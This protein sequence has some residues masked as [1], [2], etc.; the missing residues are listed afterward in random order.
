MMHSAAFLTKRLDLIGQFFRCMQ[1]TSTGFPLPVL[2]RKARRQRV[3]GQVHPPLFYHVAEEVSRFLRLQSYSSRLLQV[4][5]RGLPKARVCRLG[6][7]VLQAWLTA[8]A[9]VQY[10][11]GG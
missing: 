1:L 10:K 8:Q 3:L 11:H 4:G 5:Q 9:K 2:P 7:L 6:Y